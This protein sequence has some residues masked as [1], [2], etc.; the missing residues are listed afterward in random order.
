M[1]VTERLTSLGLIRH[2]S[3]RGMM[4]KQIQTGEVFPE[5]VDPID[6]IYTYKETNTPINNEY[7][8]AQQALDVIFGGIDDGAV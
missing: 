5:A 7:L 4:I 2:Y 8:T 3:N 1:I 6:S